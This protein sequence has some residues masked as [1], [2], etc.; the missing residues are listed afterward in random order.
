MAGDG[1][2][3]AGEDWMIDL[4]AARA[5]RQM[6]EIGH[7]TIRELVKLHRS[8][9]PDRHAHALEVAYIVRKTLELCGEDAAI[10]TFEQ[11]SL[12]HE[13]GGLAFPTRTWMKISRPDCLQLG[14]AVLAEIGHP[15]H[16]GML[17]LL[18]LDRRDVVKV[19]VPM[20]VLHL[21]TVRA[22]L[23]RTHG[24]GVVEF[25]TSG[26]DREVRDAFR[27]Y[28]TLPRPSRAGR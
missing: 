18:A 11:L 16:G 9:H 8:E 4:R 1:P 22:D 5:G 14:A 27:E 25:N 15:H 3:S 17:L 19:S 24:A 10:P 26:Y 2:A 23:E 28:T 6:A 21:V 7:M 20:Q 12:L 13:I